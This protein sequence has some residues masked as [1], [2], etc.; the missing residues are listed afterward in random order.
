MNI[1]VFYHCLFVG[2]PK[3]TFLP[4]AFC[5]VTDQMQQLRLSGLLNRA[6]YFYVGI[7]GGPESIEYARIT[8]PRKAEIQFHGTQCHTE[9]RTLLALEQHVKQNPDDLILYFHSKGATKTARQDSEHAGQWR[10]CMMRNLVMNWQ[11]CVADLKHFESVGCH[12]LTKQG[13]D[14]SQ[15]LWGGNFWWARASFLQT[16]PPLCDRTRIIIS[17]LDALESRYEAEVW[18]GNGKRL[19]TVRDYHPVNPAFRGACSNYESRN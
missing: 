14:K 16:L 13:S 11:R 8:I 5:I 9:N 12:W 18:I 3:K 17:G 7:N 4:L 15:S 6:D 10:D 1:A 2:G 19:P